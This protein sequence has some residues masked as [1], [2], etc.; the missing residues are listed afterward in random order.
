M[1]VPILWSIAACFTRIQNF[2][3][4]PERVGSRSSTSTSPTDHDENGPARFTQTNARSFEYELQNLSVP[5]NEGLEIQIVDASFVFES[6][7]IPILKDVT[8]RVPQSSFAVVMGD[9]GS[10]KTTLLRAILG[11]VPASKGEVH[12]AHRRVAYCGQASW[13]RNISI[14]RNILGEGSLDPAWYTTVV[15]ACLLDEDFQHLPQGDEYLAGSG[16]SA[17]SGGQRQRV[18]R[19]TS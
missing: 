4:L 1:A 18:V 17:L 15:D 16:G 5:Q 7:S 9:V 10:G 2:L 8:L 19:C 13:L 6:S 12:V 14:R 11:E 3:L